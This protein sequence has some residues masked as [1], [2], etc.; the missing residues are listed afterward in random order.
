MTETIASRR[1]RRSAPVEVGDGCTLC[2][3]CV[4]ACPIGALSDDLDQPLLRFVEAACVQCG[5]C[6][7]RPRGRSRAPPMIT[8]AS[9]RASRRR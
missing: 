4:S 3:S 2:L 6:K 5:R 7:A 1:E 8:S 9:A